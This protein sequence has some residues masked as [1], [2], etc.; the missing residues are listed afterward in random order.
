[1]SE[2]RGDGD[3]FERNWSTTKEAHYSTGPGA[4]PKIRSN[5]PSGSTGRRSMNC[6]PTTSLTNAS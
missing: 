1:M 2:Y 4:N 3:S 5:W 6:C